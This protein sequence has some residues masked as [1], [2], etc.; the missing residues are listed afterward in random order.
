MTKRFMNKKST[1]VDEETIRYYYRDGLSGSAMKRR[2]L[3]Q[4]KKEM[5]YV[6]KNKWGWD[7]NC[8]Y[9]YISLKV[10]MLVKF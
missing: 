8:S 6:G 3:Q 10:S 5:T 9:C 1:G 7:K 4:K 2:K